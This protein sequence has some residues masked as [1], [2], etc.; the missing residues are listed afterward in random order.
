MIRISGLHSS[1]SDLRRRRKTR[2]AAPAAEVLESRVLLAA[3][4]V[5]PGE[6]LD[7]VGRD[8]WGHWWATTPT[9]DH[10]IFASWD[11]AADWQHVRSGDFDGDSFDDIVG[12][13]PASGLWWAS[14]SDAVGSTTLVAGAWSN[15]TIWSDVAVVDLNNDGR[16]NDLVGRDHWGNWWGAIANGDGT[17]H[18]ALLTTWS[19]AVEWRDVRF[20]DLNRDNTVDIIGRAS[21]GSWWAAV[22]LAD[23]TFRNLFLANWNESAGWQDV[24]VLRGYDDPTDGE[25][26]DYRNAIVAR[27]SAGEWWALSGRDDGSIDTR[28]LTAWD[29]SRDWRDVLAA[30]LVGP[31]GPPPGGTATGEEVVGRTSDGDWYAL[32]PRTL[33]TTFIGHWNEAA[34]WRDVQVV[35]LAARSV[36]WPTTNVFIVGRTASGNWW[37]SGHGDVDPSETSDTVLINQHLTRWNE[38]AEWSDVFAADRLG[39]TPAELTTFRGGVDGAFSA[40]ITI[41]AHRAGASVSVTDLDPPPTATDPA[42]GGRVS[43]RYFVPSL[44][45]DEV[46]VLMMPR[47]LIQE[48]AFNGRGGGDAFVSRTRF[49]SD[50]RGGA[51][52]DL[53]DAVN[54]FPDDQLIGGNG[55]DMLLGDAGDQLTQ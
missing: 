29:K 27:T 9:A 51:G 25:A 43:I 14:L 55:L 7:L 46:F 24:T 34:N 2:P 54:G 11:P 50:A 1:C 32:D 49:R 37:A 10:R 30:N 22:N 48:I 3:T 40:T 35:N 18:N 28:F 44:D 4:V 23:G 21:D 36:S 41:Y 31:Y 20:F 33:T 39:G 53:L 26:G 5:D 38:A 16:G 13:D 47:A 15:V 12:W 17:F 45:Y 19:T 6:G 8:K 42:A 52:D